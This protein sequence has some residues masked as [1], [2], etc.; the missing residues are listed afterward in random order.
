MKLKDILTEK[1][2][3]D[4]EIGDTILRGK[5]KNKPVVVKD[6]GTD[7]HGQPT[8]N[9]K[10]MLSFRIKKLMPKKTNEGTCGYGKNGKIGDEPAGPHLVDKKSRDN[11]MTEGRPMFQDK[12][13]ELAY[14]DFK[15]W[16]YKNRKA[17]KNILVKAVEDGRDPG[18]DIFL[19]LR[20]VWLAWAN[21]N[22]KEYS[23]IPN[24]GPAG[25]D[26]GRALAVMMK[27]D[28]LII[29][30]SG[31]KLTDLSEKYNVRKQ[32][33]K[34]SD[35]DRG[36]YTLSYTSKKGKKYRACHTSKKKAKGQIAA[37]EGP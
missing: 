21:K 15:K 37:I 16:A 22:A 28:N 23:K 5:F 26:F 13:N 36:T 12:P 30:K 4:L 29:K 6:I 17:V 3:I 35:G 7:E 24:K 10:K 9:G 34:Q 31:N 2:E 11:K 8:I 1:Y 25:K 27:S 33:C 14:K 18:T 20:Q 19:A 32:S